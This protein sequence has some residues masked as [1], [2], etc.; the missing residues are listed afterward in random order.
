M[1]ERRSDLPL[2]DTS[3]H[4]LAWLDQIVLAIQQDA[5]RSQ[6][7]RRDLEEIQRELDAIEAKMRRQRIPPAGGHRSNEQRHASA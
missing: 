7:L 6:Q 2:S 4:F 5:G 3:A 1:S